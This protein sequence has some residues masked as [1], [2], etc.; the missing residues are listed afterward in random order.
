M[1]E[2]QDWYGI[3]S[4]SARWINSML[5][6]LVYCQIQ[7]ILLVFVAINFAV[8]KVVYGY[9]LVFAQ[10]RKSD[11]GGAI[12]QEQLSHLQLGLAT[13]IV[14]MTGYLANRSNAIKIPVPLVGNF[15]M[16]PS[17]ISFS[18]V[19]YLVRS[20]VKLRNIDCSVLPRRQVP[21]HA[22]LDKQDARVS[23]IQPELLEKKCADGEDD[24]WAASEDFSDSDNPDSL[25][26]TRIATTT[27]RIARTMTGHGQ[28]SP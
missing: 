2:D 12:F 21:K 11:K 4:R 13:Y 23:Y 9:L 27:R 5:I 28:A 24:N 20:Y 16:S 3:G 26:V 1:A 15:P 22:Q 19:F 8:C 6:G 18:S 7:P 14:L 17:I 10:N 25:M